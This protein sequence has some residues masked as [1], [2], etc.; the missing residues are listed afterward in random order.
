MDPSGS[1]TENCIAL[2]FINR[3]SVVVERTQKKYETMYRRSDTSS[4][5]HVPTIVVKSRARCL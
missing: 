1:L 2:S 5:L 4:L 3:V